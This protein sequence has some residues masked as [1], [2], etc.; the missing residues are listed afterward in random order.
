MIYFKHCF[1]KISNKITNEIFSFWSVKLFE[2]R[3]TFSRKFFSLAA[4]REEVEEKALQGTSDTPKLRRFR[5]GKKSISIHVLSLDFS[6]KLINAVSIYFRTYLFF[7]SSS[8][9]HLWN[10]HFGRDR[11]LHSEM[12]WLRFKW[13][14]R[15]SLLFI[16][17][18]DAHQRIENL[19]VLY[20]SSSKYKI[21]HPLYY[22]RLIKNI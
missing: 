1:Q 10:F 12:T 8:Q 17:F 16:P 20:R 4:Y 11:C 9:I 5:V 13:K 22:L 7:L 2:I 18:T 21:H 6:L 19:R 15:G 14:V 3:E